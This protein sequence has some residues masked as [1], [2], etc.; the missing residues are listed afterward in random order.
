[1]KRCLRYSRTKS[2][3]CGVSSC[4]A[5]LGATILS[6]CRERWML[7]FGTN[8]TSVV[9][10]HTALAPSKHIWTRDLNVCE[11]CANRMSADIFLSNCQNPGTPTDRSHNV[12]HG[13]IICEQSTALQTVKSCDNT[14]H[15]GRHKKCLPL[16]HHLWAISLVCLADYFA[17]RHTKLL[18]S[19]LWLDFVAGRQRNL[20]AHRWCDNGRHFG[21]H[22]NVCYCHIIWEWTLLL[23]DREI[24]ML[25]D[26]V[27]MADI[28]ADIENVW[29]IEIWVIW[30]TNVCEMMW[31]YFCRLSH[32]IHPCPY[33]YMLPS[34]PA[35]EI[36]Q[37][38]VAIHEGVIDVFRVLDVFR[39]QIQK[40]FTLFQYV[41]S[42]YG[43]QHR[44]PDYDRRLRDD[45]VTILA[46]KGLGLWSL[47]TGWCLRNHF[48]VLYALITHLW[49][50]SMKRWVESGRWR[51]HCSNQLLVRAR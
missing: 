45:Y 4:G 37:T 7:C 15:F 19:H 17:A 16:S 26:D 40:L 25:T 32:H 18:A 3:S 35:P 43:T 8:F 30:Q 44:C 39:I 22:K 27:T 2:C 36:A 10:D 14:R 23:V 12:C 46:E 9:T 41:C 49:S 47:L 5:S 48:S 28:L 13:H 6:P 42:H 31:L 50:T 33:M 29:E 38:L 20:H 34:L 24:S 21:R 1:M 11:T 51:G